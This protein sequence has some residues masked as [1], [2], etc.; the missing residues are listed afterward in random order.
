VSHLASSLAPSRDER[1]WLGSYGL[2][3]AAPPGAE[4][5]RRSCG[6]FAAAARTKGPVTCRRRSWEPAAIRAE[7]DEGSLRPVVQ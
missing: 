6:E 4:S 5:Q 3:P 2:T 1:T 7:H